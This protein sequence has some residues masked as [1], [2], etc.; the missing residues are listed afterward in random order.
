[1]Q[2]SPAHAMALGLPVP[3]LRKE[4]I[5]FLFTLSLGILVDMALTFK[6]VFTRVLL[7]PLPLSKIDRMTGAAPINSIN[8]ELGLNLGTSSG[9][10]GSGG[11]SSCPFAFRFRPSRALDFGNRTYTPYEAEGGV[12]GEEKEEGQGQGQGEYVI[13]HM[14]PAHVEKGKL[15]TQPRYL[16][17]EE[18]ERKII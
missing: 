9:N 16:G 10:S 7:P 1:M 18:E 2:D 15:C 5:D 3:T 17:D 6:A 8:T 14:G 4:P 12:S 13:E 11:T